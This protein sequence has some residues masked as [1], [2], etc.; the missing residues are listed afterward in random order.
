MPDENDPLVTELA[1]GVL[2]LRLN[3]PD[4]LNALNL[5]LRTA[6]RDGGD[7]AHLPDVKCILISAAGR[8][9]CPGVDLGDSAFDEWKSRSDLRES[10]IPMINALTA[11][12][13]PI[14]TAVQGVAAG[15][16]LSLALCGDIVL[17]SP[18]ASFLPVFTSIGIVPD[19]GL[20]H[21]LLRRMTYAAAFQ[22]L[23]ENER[24]GAEEAVRRGIANT[25]LPAD[26]FTGR[27][28][29]YARK[30]AALPGVGAIAG[31]EVLEQAMRTT[32]V[33]QL[34]VE[35]RRQLWATKDEDAA[36]FRHE[37]FQRLL[38]GAR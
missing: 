17:A 23:V 1:D 35:A 32:L 20:T 7:R 3:R 18:N 13:T 29:E 36:A 2:H 16:G 14:V 19:A 21:F 26:D 12:H 5:E 4:K 31:K 9:F 22:W 27:A 34:E 25:L 37:R 11:S 8:G 6:L 10:F 28:L 24:V 38:G 33:E 15:A 30:I